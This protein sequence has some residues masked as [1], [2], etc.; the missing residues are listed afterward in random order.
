[1]V[2]S[3]VSARSA[4]DAGSW[5]LACTEYRAVAGATR[6]PVAYEG[7]AQAAWW[8]DDAVT[9]VGAREQAYRGHQDLGDALGAARA[10]TALAWDSLLF[11]LGES[12]AL[13]WWGRAGSLLEELGESAEHGWHAVRE[14]ELALEVGHDPDRA[15]GAARRAAAVGKR[16][17]LGD[18]EVV[19]L[20]LLGLAMTS[21]G[22]VREGMARLDASV[23]AATSGDVPDPMWIGKVCCWVIAAC[24][25][26]KDVTRAADWCRRVEALC[27]E[28]DL[29]PLFSV[30][31]IQHA[32]V[33]V[34]RGSWREAEQE[35]VGVLD[36]LS[37]SRRASRFDAVVQLGELRRRQGRLDEAEALFAQAEFHPSAIVGRARMLM[38]DGDPVTAW[39]TM[40]SLLGQMPPDGRLARA[41]VLLPAVL[42]AQA[43]GCEGAARVL[44]A[45]LRATAELTGTD[46]MMA[47]A[48][49]AEASLEPP[50]AAVPLLSEAVRRFNAADLRFD[51]AHTRLALAEALLATGAAAPARRHLALATQVLTELSA[52]EDL[53]WARRLTD[54]GGVPSGG[55][56]SARERQV[57]RL[58]SQGMSNQQIAGSLVLSE[59]T[60]HRH[61]ANILTKLGQTSRTGAASHAI[62]AGLL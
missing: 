22:D 33:Q 54:T 41:D 52:G 31:R 8:L 6:D 7:L 19:S 55:P 20:A 60:V 46:W 62:H 27:A 39:T 58:V 5:L 1:M 32:T 35:L 45:E 30:C 24:N 15:L 3:L 51:E 26:N 16:L 36:R 57:L 18:L 25:Q 2:A 50:G 38:A 56:L 43:A 12:V 11:G 37:A 44:A 47:T 13:G 48:S 29:A 14:A 10:A 23:A 17:G 28:R 42:I 21:A 40:R 49:V 9:C 61:V 53:T 4:L 34:A 59:H